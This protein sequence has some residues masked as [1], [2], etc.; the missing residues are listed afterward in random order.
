MSTNLAT[1]EPASSLKVNGLQKVVILLLAMDEKDA[2]DVLRQFSPDEIKKL[3][4]TAKT[5]PDVAPEQLREVVQQFSQAFE[6]SADFARTPNDVFAMLDS[7]L[8]SSP[9][10]SPDEAGEQDSAED[11]GELEIIAE[12]AV[13]APA[14]GKELVGESPAFQEK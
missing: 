8:F 11:D 10:S 12:P 4:E 13:N 14:E 1:L 5:M 3:G 6:D 2:N 9:D 7:S